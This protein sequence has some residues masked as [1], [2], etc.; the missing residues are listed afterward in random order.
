ML[1]VKLC[2]QSPNLH[3]RYA[4]AMCWTYNGL[5]VDRGAGFP[6]VGSLYWTEQ[7]L[8]AVG[9]RYSGFRDGGGMDMAPYAAEAKL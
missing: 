5:T 2:F 8:K 9:Q 4:Y 6:P 7:T 3:V 1:Y